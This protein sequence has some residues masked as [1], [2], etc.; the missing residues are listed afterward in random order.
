M[1]LFSGEF[2]R[3]LSLIRLWAQTFGHKGL[4]SMNH[5][6]F[7]IILYLVSPAIEAEE[8]AMLSVLLAPT[9]LSFPLPVL[10][11]PGGIIHGLK[12]APRPILP[13][14]LWMQ[15]PKRGMIPSRLFRGNGLFEPYPEVSARWRLN[16]RYQRSPGDR[17]SQDW[18]A[19]LSPV[20]LSAPANHSPDRP[21][22]VKPTGE[23]PR[24]A[25]P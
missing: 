15:S 5:I 16:E 13:S 6:F 4:H 1:K 22:S 23:S 21:Q 11:A 18:R 12:P 3:I 8:S 17:A 2:V 24:K 9:A 14:M 7:A 20:I 25:S 19:D 10:T